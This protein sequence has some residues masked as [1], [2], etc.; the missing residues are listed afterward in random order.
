MLIG[1]DVEKG[2]ARVVTIG[3]TDA[4]GRITIPVKATGPHGLHAIGAV[5]VAA[6]SRVAWY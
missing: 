5:A 3:R 6:T 4:N 2:K 1:A